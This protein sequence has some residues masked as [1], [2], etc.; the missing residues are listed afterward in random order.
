MGLSL[1]C[2]Y[3]EGLTTERQTAGEAML[4]GNP[5][6]N[7]YDT[8]RSSFYHHIVL[9][10]KPS[11]TCSW[12]QLQNTG[13]LFTYWDYTDRWH[14]QHL[15]PLSRTLATY[16]SDP[17]SVVSVTFLQR[18]TLE[19]NWEGRAGKQEHSWKQRGTPTGP[20]WVSSHRIVEFQQYYAV[21]Y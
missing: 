9:G 21:S 12:A 20:W 1:L 5:K 7:I 4:W 8:S 6:I 11:I 3:S 19:G 2:L 16:P 18:T 15:Q 17:T 14:E 10:I 13:L